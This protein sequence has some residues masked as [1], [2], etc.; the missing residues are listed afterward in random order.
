MTEI[1]EKIVASAKKHE[2]IEIV[3]ANG[4]SEQK[5]KM[6][7]KMAINQVLVLIKSCACFVSY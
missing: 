3:V 1:F 5:G 6:S 4:E 2:T 7:V